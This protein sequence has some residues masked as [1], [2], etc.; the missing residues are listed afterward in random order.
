MIDHTTKVKPPRKLLHVSDHFS[1]YESEEEDNSPS[2]SIEEVTKLFHTMCQE[3]GLRHTYQLF[4]SKRFQENLS[5]PQSIWDE[6]EPAIKERVLEIKKKLKEKANN[7]PKA[8]QTSKIPDQYPTKKIQDHVANLCSSL[9]DLGVEGKDESTDDE[10]ITSFAYMVTRA[11]LEPEGLVNT[12]D[13]LDQTLQARAHL[14]YGNQPWYPNKV[15]AI[16]DGGADSCIVGKH[17]KVLFYTGRFANLIGCDPKNT[18]TDKVPIVTALIKAKS[19][20]IGNHP[21]LLKIHEAPYNSHS[22]ITLLSEYQI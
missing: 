10:A 5:I 6:L 21:V 20:S 8:E 4:Q 16:A 1:Q 3:S 9:A 19:S 17:A 15:F 12:E 7:I 14:E 11:K 13:S 18:R 2:K 22:P